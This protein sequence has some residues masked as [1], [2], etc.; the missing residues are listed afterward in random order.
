MHLDYAHQIT[1][2]TTHRL[3]FHYLST[4]RIRSNQEKAILKQVSYSV[5]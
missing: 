1:P 4:H 5:K 3:Q 2:R